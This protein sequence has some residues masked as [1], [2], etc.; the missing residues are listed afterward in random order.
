MTGWG[1]FLTCYYVAWWVYLV[2]SARIKHRDHGW[3]L[4]RSL[5]SIHGSPSTTECQGEKRVGNTPFI[6]F[7]FH[8]LTSIVW[9]HVFEILICRRATFFV[10]VGFFLLS[11]RIGKEGRECWLIWWLWLRFLWWG[12]F[13]LCSLARVSLWRWDQSTGP[14]C[15][16]ECGSYCMV[17]GGVRGQK[18]EKIMY[19]TILF[20]LWYEYL[21]HRQA[22]SKMSLSIYL[23]SKVRTRMGWEEEGGHGW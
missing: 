3:R 11:W 20:C 12:N 15:L 7:L 5:L 23:A 19:N 4:F 14:R 9:T 6:V 13:S 16:R 2:F 22:T 21:L 1:C 18:R 10:R 8:L 17:V